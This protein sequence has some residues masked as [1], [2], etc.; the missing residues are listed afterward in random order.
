MS[1]R[2]DT[3]ARALDAAMRNCRMPNGGRPAILTPADTAGVRAIVDQAKADSNALEDAWSVLHGLFVAQGMDPAPFDALIT[4]L[5]KAQTTHRRA[6]YR[7]LQSLA[8]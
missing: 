4:E 2:T 3:S 8:R 7:A 5:D 6:A 1:N